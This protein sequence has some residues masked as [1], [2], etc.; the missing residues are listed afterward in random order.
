MCEYNRHPV[1]GHFTIN[2]S[3]VLFIEVEKNI[4]EVG[5]IALNA[6]VL[7]ASAGTIYLTFYCIENPK[8]CYGSCPTF[9]NDKGKLVAEGFSRAIA[10]KFE[11]PDID[12]IGIS[13]DSA[14]FIKLKMRNEALETQGVKDVHLLELNEKEGTIYK[15]IQNKFIE[16]D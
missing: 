16:V 10:R 6:A 8:A 11:Y 1:P 15:T 14:G 2:S 4:E 5:T 12:D 13:P 9:Y 7:V 3:E